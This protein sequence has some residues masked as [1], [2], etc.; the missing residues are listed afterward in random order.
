MEYVIETWNFLKNQVLAMDLM[1]VLDI[2][3]V[4]CILYAVFFFIRDRRAGKL[5]IGVAVIIGLQVLARA[6]GF[7]ALLFIMENIFQV[8]LI[9]LIIVFQPELR[10]AL[11][12]LG[13][14]TY[15][16]KD[17][18]DHKKEKGQDRSSTKALCEAVTQLSASKTGALIAIERTTKLA[19]YINTGVTFD[20]EVNTFLI[21]NIFFNKAPLHDGAMFIR[22]GRIVAAGCFL[23]LSQNDSIIKDLG[24]RHRAGIGLSEVSDAVVIIVSEETGTISVAQDGVLRR[25]YTFN[26]LKKLLDRMGQTPDEEQKKEQTDRK[27]D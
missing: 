23:P 13:G 5:V 27:E 12:K 11:E 22:K 17:I 24:T 3:F 7:N 14:E 25:N 20:A 18:A 21:R 4:A 19:E 15:R 6:A 26:S 9:A 2:L 1:D 8:G 16:L 10:S